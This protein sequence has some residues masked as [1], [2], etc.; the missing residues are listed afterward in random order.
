MIYLVLSKAEYIIG[1]VCITI[2]GFSG[3]LVAI[4]KEN[5]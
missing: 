1:D 4:F 5:F 3:V 2:Y